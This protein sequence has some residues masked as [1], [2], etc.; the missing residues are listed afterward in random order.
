ML[1][2]SPAPEPEPALEG[3]TQYI[4][5]C[6]T[7]VNVR[8]GASSSTRKLGSL[9]KGA[10]VKA[11]AKSGNWVKIVYNKGYAYVFSKYVSTNGKPEATPAGKTGTIYHC[12]EWVNVRAKA[13][14]TSAK[15]G[16]AKKGAA[17]T[18]K[19]ASGNWYLVDYNGTDAYIYNRYLKVS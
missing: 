7:S 17:Y 15:L 16:I 3:T 13:S 1:F 18:V 4:V 9:K 5:N 12:N 19:G 10:E 11:V 2:R 6:H 8:Q 14:S